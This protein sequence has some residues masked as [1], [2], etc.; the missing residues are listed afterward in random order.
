MKDA[1]VETASWTRRIGALIVDWAACLLALAV[2]VP[3]YGGDAPRWVNFATLGVFVLE[4]AVFTALAGGSFGQLA[5]RLR[6]V[7]A[8][9]RPQPPSL[10]VALARQILVALVIPPLV[11]RPDGR[12]LHD[13]MARTATVP[14]EEYRRLAGR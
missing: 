8:D 11:F 2:F 6:V 1:A 12:G 5:T 13:L 7:Q 10:L 14:L 9:G 4:S 3:V